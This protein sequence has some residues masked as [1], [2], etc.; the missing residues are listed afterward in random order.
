MQWLSD[1]PEVIL[2]VIIC[3]PFEG[4]SCVYLVRVKFVEQVKMS[5]LNYGAFAKRS[6]GN[7]ALMM[8][9]FFSLFS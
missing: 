2:L 6:Q 3:L 8:K 4:V 5:L 7:T 1:W 9:G